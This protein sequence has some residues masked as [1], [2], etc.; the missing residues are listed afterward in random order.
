M[1]S[2]VQLI[3]ACFAIYGG[4]YFLKQ[5]AAYLKIKKTEENGKNK[6]IKDYLP[7][8]LEYRQKYKAIRDKYDLER[9]WNEGTNIP[10]AYFSEINR[11]QFEHMEMLEQ[12]RRLGYYV[13]DGYFIDY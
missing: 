7:E 10:E 5:Y 11:L 9:K 3:V 6:F 13:E 12:Q 2:L 4:Y 8:L 1:K